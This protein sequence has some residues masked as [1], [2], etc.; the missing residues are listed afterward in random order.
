MISLSSHAIAKYVCPHLTSLTKCGASDISDRFPES[1]HWVKNF[2]VNT[3]LRYNLKDPARAIAFAFLRRSE[4]AFEE[5]GMGVEGLREYVS[6]RRD[7]FSLYFRT[8]HR[9]E[10]AVA[11]AYQ[12]GDYLRKFTSTNLFTHGDG[13]E[14]EHLNGVYN[15]SRHELPETGH[16]TWITNEGIAANNAYISFVEFESVLEWIGGVADQLSS[17]DPAQQSENGT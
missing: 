2:V 15:A 13:S 17:P 9:L 10:A 5:Y 11:Q 6:D 14:W 4:A 1:A 16:T 7:R 8:L 3:M 12:A